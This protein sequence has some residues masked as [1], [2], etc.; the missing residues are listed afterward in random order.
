MVR[1]D[2]ESCVV[3]RVGDDGRTAGKRLSAM[4]V[5]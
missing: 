5:L 2:G 4:E 3:S 1:G